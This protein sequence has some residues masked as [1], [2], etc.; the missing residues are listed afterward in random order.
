MRWLLL[1]GE[2]MRGRTM[3]SRGKNCRAFSLR[4]D[5]RGDTFLT[6]LPGQGSQSLLF[7]FQVQPY[8]VL[9][10]LV[11]GQPPLTYRASL[12]PRN[13]CS[14]C[15]WQGCVAGARAGGTWAVCSSGWHQC[16]QPL[17]QLQ[18]PLRTP[19]QEMLLSDDILLEPIP[20]RT[21]NGPSSGT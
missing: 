2:N 12:T 13:G 3:R 16:G 1:S 15:R 5:R 19:G 20:P 21:E 9:L 4:L 6:H 17:L 8:E 11:W 10:A 7:P 18:H 14:E